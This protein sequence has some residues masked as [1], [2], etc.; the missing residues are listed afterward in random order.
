MTRLLLVTPT[1]HGYHRGIARA[2]EGRGYEV[3]THCY[4]GFATLGDKLRNKALVELPARLGVDSHRSAEAWATERALAA[5]RE[6]SP[7]RIIVIK[8]DTLGLDFWDEVERRELPRILWL[9][10]DLHRHRYTYEFLREVGPVVS[11]ARSE[12]EGLVERGVNAC[13]VP[14][15]FDPGLVGAP[16]A[17]RTDEIVFVGS[18]YPNRVE[19]LQELHAAG[20]PVRAYGR[21]WSK[22]PFDRLRTWE[23]VRPRLPAERDISLERA[24]VVQA[25][26][27]AAINVHGLQA[28][29]AMRTFEVPGMGGLQLIDRPDVEDF[30]DPG[31]EALVF[32]SAEELVELARRALSDRA[33]SERI[34]EAGQ[35]RTLAEHTFAHRIERLDTLWD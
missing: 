15:G 14:N 32:G 20:L 17:R 10:D 8:G 11:Y 16:T 19:L 23:V 26:A 24:Y 22:H 9:Y 31:T 7:D 28:G 3:I 35:R 21:Q 1:F 25:E 2:L 29:L 30:Y 12:A 13:W 5:L 18:R 4:D 34:R 33:W 6:S 27:A